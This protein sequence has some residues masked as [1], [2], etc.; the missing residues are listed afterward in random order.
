LADFLENFDGEWRLERRVGGECREGW[1]LGTG[2]A[3][4][5]TPQHPCAQVARARIVRTS[6]IF[7]GGAL[8]PTRHPFG[9]RP[10]R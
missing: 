8:P 6:I 9:Y 1:S 5:S 3:A 2:P 4:Q 7:S 10:K